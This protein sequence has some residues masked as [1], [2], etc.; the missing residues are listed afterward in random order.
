MKKSSTP[1]YIY[2]AN[3]IKDQIRNGNYRIEEILP[4][5]RII[6]KTLFVSRP[7][8]RRAI[9]L[10]EKER[11]VA[12]NPSIG[13]RV[14]RSP[15]EKILIGYLVQ[16]LQDPFHI[17]LIRELDNLLHEYNGGLIAS[18]G[19][20]DSRLLTM[21]I[22]HAVK[23]HQL[24]SEGQTDRVPTVY[25]GNVNGRVDTVVS[26]V[27][28]GM[29]HLY[30]HLRRLGHQHTAYAS[31]FSERED[32]QYT[33]LME[34]MARDNYSLKPE[35][36]FIVDPHDRSECEKVALWIKNAEAPPTALI[37]YNDWLAIAIMKEAKRVGLDIPLD[38]SITGYDNLYMSSL[39]QV[40]LTTIRFSRRE[41]AEKIIKILFNPHP[42]ENIVETVETKLI[43]RE[44]TRSV[45]GMQT[46]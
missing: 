38:L 9:E 33:Y 36:H 4:G 20:D 43:V 41:T 3:Y 16:D 25:I 12:C 7:S 44:S 2:V 24:Y 31:P 40:P 17:E 26:D 1:K 35:Y 37:C 18:Q 5:Q 39:L 15:N 10:L 42:L 45:K 8:V 32:V 46:R 28:S 19:T 21:G 27:R 14:L 23:H 6:A 34:A 29:G 13:S 11:I 22:T 30:E